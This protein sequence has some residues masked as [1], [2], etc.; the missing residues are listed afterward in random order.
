MSMDADLMQAAGAASPQGP[1]GSFEL[2]F[3]DAEE[4]GQELPAAFRT[5]YP[6]S[7]TLPSGPRP[8]VCVNFVLSRDGRVSFN[9]PGQDRK[10][11]RLNSSHIQKSRMP[12]SA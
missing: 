7:W 2:L 9:E 12:S 10:S 11:T 3:D 4:A 6:G 1:G 8:Y 5:V